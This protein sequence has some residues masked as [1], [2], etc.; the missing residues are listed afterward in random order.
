MVGRGGHCFLLARGLMWHGLRCAV[1]SASTNFS[2]VRLVMG[3]SAC[4]CGVCVCV[5]LCVW[6]CSFACRV[7][8]QCALVLAVGWEVCIALLASA[9]NS[10]ANTL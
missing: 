9:V 6:S 1:A 5:C 10:T 4:L 3:V 8:M 2:H 7:S